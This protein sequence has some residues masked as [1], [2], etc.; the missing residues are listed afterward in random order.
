MV[1][2]QDGEFAAKIKTY[3]LHG[4]SKDAWRRFSDEGYQHYQATLPG[5]KYNMMDLQAAIGI[6]Q[7]E[8]VG[9]GLKRRNEIWQSYNQAFSD[10]PVGLPAS[11]EP[12]TVHSARLTR[13]L[14]TWRNLSICPMHREVSRSGRAP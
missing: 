12:E 9:A 4:M 5:F 13:W 6:H 2:T 10:L 3:A 11:D 7:L 1:T 8:R 14:V